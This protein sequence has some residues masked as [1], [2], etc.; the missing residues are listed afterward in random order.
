MTAPLAPTGGA[1]FV[2]GV[3]NDRRSSQTE[4][5]IAADAAATGTASKGFTCYYTSTF[6]SQCGRTVKK[7]F[8]DPYRFPQEP[9]P[10]V[11][12]EYRN[13][14][15]CDRKILTTATGQRQPAPAAQPAT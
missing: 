11:P 6:R 5:A 15:T 13:C 14:K 1:A 3:V 12:G 8:R 9:L 7:R 10:Y 2:I 4:H